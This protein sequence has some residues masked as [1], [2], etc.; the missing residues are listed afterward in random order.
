MADWTII[1]EIKIEGMPLGRHIY[2]PEGWATRAMVT[3]PVTPVT[4][5]WTRHCPAFN[6]GRVGSCTGNAAAGALMTDPFYVPGRELTETDAVKFYSEATQHDP[7]AGSYPP[8][9]TGSSGYAIALALEA[10]GII[11]SFSHVT[12]LEGALGA[13]TLSPGI[14]GVSWM[15]T[16]DHPQS[17]GEAQM[18]PLSQVRGGH[19]IQAFG[20]DVEQRQVWFYQ[21]WGPTW[22]P[23]GNGTFWMS[24]DTL[25]AQLSG[26]RSDGTFFEVAK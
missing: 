20:I 9:D 12:T 2:R 10:D 23:L 7:I 25:D 1:P 26:M 3:P 16:F 24:F 22:G 17:N 4:T 15:D 14:F 5:K 6:Q 21:S 19:E 8:M 18:T 13:L 11:S